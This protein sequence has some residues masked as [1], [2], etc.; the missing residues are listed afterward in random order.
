MTGMERRLHEYFGRLRRGEPIAEEERA[1]MF[2]YAHSKEHRDHLRELGEFGEV[3]LPAIMIM[4]G[5]RGIDAQRFLEFYR[6]I[7]ERGGAA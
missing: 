6:A 1:E 3:W 4:T 5:G 2:K 7:K